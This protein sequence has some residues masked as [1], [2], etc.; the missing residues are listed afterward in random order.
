ML[1]CLISLKPKPI[2]VTYVKRFLHLVTVT[3]TIFIATERIHLYNRETQ[4]LYA[5]R[6]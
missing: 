3:L 1:V 4:L 6:I 5:S 2:K